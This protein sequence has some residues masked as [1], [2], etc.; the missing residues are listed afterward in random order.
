VPVR[1]LTVD[2]SPLFL[3]VLESIIASSPDLLL[4]GRA[5]NGREAVRK[6]LDLSPDVVTLDVEMPIMDGLATLVRIMEVKPTRVIMVS[7]HTRSATAT[8]IKALELGA[9]D[10]VGKPAHSLRKGYEELRS[11]LVGKI[12]AIGA[13]PW[14]T[15]RPRGAVDGGI[16][17]TGR[18]ARV[19]IIGGSTGGTTVLAG[20]LNALPAR[21]RSTVVVV[22]HLPGLYT[23][24]FARRLSQTAACPVFHA[25]EGGLVEPGS[26]YLAPGGFH[27]SV[28][29]NT[30]RV[31]GGEPVNGHQPSIDVAMSSVARRFAP[32]VCGVLLTGMGRDG[33][34]G[35]AEIRDAGGFTVAQD[36]ETSVVFGM[37]RAA[38]A[39]GKVDLVLSDSAIRTELA[40]LVLN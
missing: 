37:P 9:C 36:E 4:V 14:H 30:F 35:I 32:D 39:T 10:F 26:V 12:A 21:M 2:D 33:A 6:I 25:R 31:Q 28:Y 29:G 1:V 40:A 38:I 23:Q 22:Q 27:L 3:E 17:P 20:I 11:D 16:F 8:T 18:K 15:A 34:A 5:G 19:V 24:E 13:R 7:S